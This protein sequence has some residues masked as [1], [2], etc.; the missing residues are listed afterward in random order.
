MVDCNECKANNADGERD[1]CV[2]LSYS[3]TNLCAEHFFGHFEKRVKRTIREFRLLRG[4][5][6]IAVGLSGGKDST[7]LLMCLKPICDSMRIELVA[8]TVDEGIHN[9][10]EKLLENAGKLCEELG[11]KHVVRTY[12]KDIGVKMDEVMAQDPN[13]SPCTYCGVFRRWLLNKA[14]REEGCDML[15]TGHNLDDAAQTLLMNLLRNEPERIARFGISGATVEEANFIPRIKPLMR[16]PEREVALYVL[17]KNADFPFAECTYANDAFRGELR[18]L[19]NSLE[20]KY[21]GTKMNVLNSFLS[22]R[23]A[24]GSGSRSESGSKSENKNSAHS[25]KLNACT[26]C[27]EP[28]SAKVCKRCELLE[29]VAVGTSG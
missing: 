11:V 15:A 10:R 4:A 21:P 1:A 2:Y 8:I 28:A 14:A 3:K 6:K 23:D 22:M 26:V 9:Y 13:S 19:L 25:R 5:K 7:A 18:A 16:A 12:D 27:G 24:G 17:L 20:E 29:K